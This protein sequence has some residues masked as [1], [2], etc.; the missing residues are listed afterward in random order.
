MQEGSE[1]CSYIT[2]LEGGSTRFGC[3]YDSVGIARFIFGT[4]L[5]GHQDIRIKETKRLLEIREQLDQDLLLGER[6]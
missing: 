4:G 6:Q 1:S 5:V 3:V 2:E